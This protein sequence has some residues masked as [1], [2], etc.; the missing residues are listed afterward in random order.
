MT[1]RPP[2][3]GKLLDANTARPPSRSF[4]DGASGS[5]RPSSSPRVMLQPLQPPNSQGFAGGS[6]TA[7]DDKEYLSQLKREIRLLASKVSEYS[8]AVETDRRMADSSSLL[9]RP[10]TPGSANRPATAGGQVSAGQIAANIDTFI[11]KA[12]AGKGAEQA[13]SALLELLLTV[14]EDAQRCTLMLTEKRAPAGCT[15]P[16]P[17]SASGRMGSRVPVTEALMERTLQLHGAVR[18]EEDVIRTRPLT[19]GP[20]PPAAPGDSGLSVDLVTGLLMRL[21]DLYEHYGAIADGQR[22]V[23]GTEGGKLLGELDAALAALTATCSPAGHSKLSDAAARVQGEAR[24]AN[25]TISTAL[26]MSSGGAGAEEELSAQLRQARTELADARKEEEAMKAKLSGE[27][28]GLQSNLKEKSAEVEALQRQLQDATRSAERMK[29][30]DASA[31]AQDLMAVAKATALEASNAE[32]RYGSMSTHTPH[33]AI[34]NSVCSYHID[35]KRSRGSATDVAHLSN[36]A[37]R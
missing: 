14:L 28:A 21:A 6:S 29:E 13:K 24:N 27:V 34:I 8:A 15:V 5:G 35:Y 4:A 18:P 20:K 16:A 32:L 22:D 12:S 23:G 7:A 1:A 37:T 2:S 17:S 11:E 33:A 30:E 31:A 36:S 9:R 19:G 25:L 26:A 3:R 10:L